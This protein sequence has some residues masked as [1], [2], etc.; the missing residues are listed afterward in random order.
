M[1]QPHH[2]SALVLALTAV[3]VVG[4]VSLGI[5]IGKRFWP[6]D[7]TKIYS[8]TPGRAAARRLA[9]AL[10]AAAAFVV[11]VVV[12]WATGH[13]TAALVVFLALIVFWFVAVIGL[14]VAASRQITKR[15]QEPSSVQPPNRDGP[16]L[17]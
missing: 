11:A 8:T 15:G 1:L 6:T 10:G 5:I 13:P 17:A 2:L 12:I 14:G 3:L 16:G 7:M 9:L 4:A